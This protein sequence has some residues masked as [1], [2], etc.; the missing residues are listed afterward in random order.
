MKQIKYVEGPSRVKIGDVSFTI[1]SIVT[2]DSEFANKLLKIAYLK[3]E[4]VIEKKKK[5]IKKK[6]ISEDKD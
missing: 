4:E 2:V 5:S 6:V 1:D 3:F